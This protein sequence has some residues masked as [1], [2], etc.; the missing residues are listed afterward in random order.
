MPTPRAYEDNYDATARDTKVL[1]PDTKPFLLGK[2][3]NALQTI[4]D[5]KRQGV[6]DALF[7]DGNL[8]AG[9]AIAVDATTGDVTLG[10][11][12]VYIRG[13]VHAVVAASF[14]I[15]VDRV[16]AVGVRLVTDTQGFETR[17]GLLGTI[18]GSSAQA[19]PGAD[20]ETQLATWGWDGDGAAGDFFPVYSVDNGVVVSQDPP[21]QIS[22]V[23]EALA[24]YD[25][26]ANGH[27]VVTG[28][29]VDPLGLTG[30]DQ[31]FSV[32]EG[33]ANIFGYKR[34]RFTSARLTILE[35]PDLRAVAGETH[36]FADGGSG[37]FVIPPRNLPLSSVDQVSI[38]SEV[39][40]TISR[41]A[42][43]GT[44]DA[45][46]QS[47]VTEIVSVVQGGT[48][49]VATTDF[50]L[51]G[52]VI[53]WSPAGAEPAPGSTFDI[54][55]RY[56]HNVA[57]DSW[58]ATSITVSGAVTGTDV[59]VDYTWKL[60]RIDTI[61]TKRD[62]TVF[63]QKGISSALSP[64]PARLPADTIRI[65][66]VTNNWGQTPDVRNV[67][68]HA[69]HYS[70]IEDMRDLIFDLFDLTAQNKLLTDIAARE[71]TT[72]RGQFVDALHDD[73]LRDA[74]IAQTGAVVDRSLRLPIDPTIV[75]V[76]LASAQL[77]P[78]T[79]EVVLEQLLE[80]GSMLINPYQA[81]DPM[82]ARASL[83]PATDIWTQTITQWAS[84]ATRMIVNGFG[85]RSWRTTQQRMELLRSS[86]AV[87]QFL[88]QISVSFVIEGFGANEALTKV[89]FDGIDV[90]PAAV[91]A[92]ANGQVTGSFAIPAN[93]LAGT[94]EV[95]FTGVTPN[96]STATAAFVGSG[97]ITT[98]VLRQV[99]T[100]SVNRWQQDQ[101]NDN[102][103][104]TTSD[105][106][107]QTFTLREGRHLTGLDLKF[108]A[109]GSAANLVVIQIRE[110][111]N[112][113]PTSTV[114]AE[115]I[116][117]GASILTDGSFTAI[118]FT[119]PVFIP[120]GVEHA[121]VIM[122]DDAAHAVA[123]AEIGEFDQALGWVTAQPYTTGVLLS[124]S[125]AST[126]TP[127]QGTDLTFRLRGA[128]FSATQT[129][130]DLGTHPVTDMTDFI[131]ALG[132]EAPS[133]DTE[134][135]VVLTRADATTVSAAP[136]R[137]VSFAEKITENVSV[138]AV[139]RGSVIHSPTLYPA[140]Q[141]IF[142]AQADAGD[143]ASRAIPC[144]L[145]TR[146]SVTFDCLLPGASGVTPT[147]GATAT[148]TAM[149]LNN[150]TL[151]GDGWEERT[152]L[153]ADFDNNE[154]RLFIGLAGS[155]KDRP[156]VKAI[157]AAALAV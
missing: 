34:D 142:G 120:E 72:K 44:T 36:V 62:G 125:N 101:Q 76:S 145:N 89:T 8:V 55:Y 4:Q 18:A 51:T 88:R 134:V 128:R 75:N 104:G 3:I 69:V 112:G 133:A 25:R 31:I 47:S 106:L 84:N 97:T 11:A 49:Y 1:V 110:V 40:E 9:G 71:P 82:P 14:T 33:T 21:P 67:A 61:A 129:T 137:T 122:T 156:Q 105:P 99:T 66:D 119:A 2:D 93:V 155:P 30:N 37:S 5:T 59:I 154:G 50:V 41:G 116:L 118:D 140:A 68:V 10:L 153:I 147:F 64:A 117:P 35:E 98:Q 23:S 132:V 54:T 79:Q 113:I 96:G 150:T 80:T 29:R 78:F 148:P 139:L 32:S 92:D 124:S 46:G 22:G 53:D 28:W 60:P 157:R 56:R 95:L 152:Y 126:W 138:A 111:V 57:A 74:G 52:D 6:A 12:Q 103:Q 70:T 121:L 58:D 7:Q 100:V 123:I 45:L 102:N 87:A 91:T 83:D 27:Y 15:P 86:T 130:I 38:K 77:L 13:L 149:V 20:R 48:T 107:A 90:T 115:G 85:D 39:S 143:Y 24:R 26:E 146:V 42:A 17:P 73:D 135:E 63:Y 136:G 81:F 19:E 94:K 131:A 114:V 109:V 141:L 43:S 127:H 16:V 151:L 144:G 65:A 108:T